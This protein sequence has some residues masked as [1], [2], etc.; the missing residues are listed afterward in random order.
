[1][2]WKLVSGDAVLSG[3][4]LTFGYEDVNLKATWL[5]V[6]EEFAYTGSEQTYEILV[7]G[8]Y[9]LEVWGA[10]GGGSNGGLGGYSTGTMFFK[11]GQK[12]YLNVGGTTSSGTGGYNGGGTVTGN[13]YG[14]GGATHIATSSGLLSSLSSS[15]SSILIVGSGGGGSG[16]GYAGGSGGGIF[17][18]AGVGDDPGKAGTQTGG[19]AANNDCGGGSGSFGQGGTG[20]WEEEALGGG[21]AGFYG[22]GSGGGSANNGSGGGGSSYIGN[23]LLTNKVMYCYNCTASSDTAT[24][25]IS[26]TCTNAAATENCS[27]QGNGYAKVTYIGE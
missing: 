3:N 5:K 21:G 9:K 18:V 16:N 14:G 8:Y 25:T 24:K 4:K 2:G 13:V 11:K 10:Q 20:S 22:G 1:M 12:I 27:K 26:T 23:S 7:S 17:G 6:V 19:G 15:Q